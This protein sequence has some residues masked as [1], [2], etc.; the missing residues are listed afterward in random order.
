MWLTFFLAQNKIVK[1]PLGRGKFFGLPLDRLE[2]SEEKLP[3]G[4]VS[5]VAY[6]QENGLDTLGIFRLSG[7]AERV[8][9]LRE[10]LEKG[11]G[12]KAVASDPGD[13]HAVAGLLKAFLRELPEPL[14]T[15]ELYKPLLTATS[16]QKSN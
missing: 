13:L 2:M 11:E 7:S 6:L 5:M 16:K 15:F 4:V 9:E 8:N 3:V 1:T 14:L 10:G 12:L